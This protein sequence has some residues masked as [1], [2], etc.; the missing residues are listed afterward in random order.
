V[1]IIGAGL[2]DAYLESTGRECESRG[3]EFVTVPVDLM[4]LSSIGALWRR[5]R[6]GTLALCC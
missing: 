6:T 2:S 4:D 5:A 3:V 1:N